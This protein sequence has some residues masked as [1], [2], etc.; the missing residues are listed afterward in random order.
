M[1]CVLA[2]RGLWVTGLASREDN[3]LKLAGGHCASVEAAPIWA[4]AFLCGCLGLLLL[5]H[6]AAP[7]VGKLEGPVWLGGGGAAL[8]TSGQPRPECGS[9][10]W[11]SGLRTMA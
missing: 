1:A 6:P 5:A 7:G 8:D 2:S 11:G 3:E 4:L 10:D 9:E